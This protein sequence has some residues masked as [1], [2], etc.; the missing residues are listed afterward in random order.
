MLRVR[1]APRDQRG[2][3]MIEVMV[4]S[5]VLAIGVLGLVSL[6]DGAN[7]ALGANKEREGATNVARQVVE[8]VDSLAYTA[9]DPTTITSTLQSKPGLANTGGAGG[10]TVT[11]RGLSYQVA[12]SVTTNSTPINFKRVTATVTPAA[13]PSLKVTQSTLMFP[14]GISAGVPPVTNIT[15]NVASPVTSSSTTSVTFT[16]TTSG[17]PSGVVFFV[18]GNPVG[19]ATG[20]GST[21]TYPWSISG[22]SDGTYVISA[23]SFNSSG[24]YSD[25]YTVTF[26]LERSVPAAPTG[27]E[28]GYDPFEGSVDSQWFAS[29]ERNVVGYHVYRQ[30][31]SPTLG[32]ATQVN[33]GTVASPVY[34]VTSLNCTDASP[35]TGSGAVTA[36]QSSSNAVDGTKSF[37]LSKPAGVAAG[38]VLLAT[39]STN[40]TPTVTAPSG[41]TLAGSNQNGNNGMESAVYYKVATASEPATYTWTLSHKQDTTGGIVDYSGVDTTNPIDAIQSFAGNSG[42]A[43]GPPVTTTTANDAIVEAVGFTGAAMY[44]WTPVVP[45]GMTQRFHGNANGSESVVADKSQATAGSSG[46]FFTQADT[47]N[48]SSGWVAQT[49]ALKSRSISVNYWV[50]PCYYDT[51]SVLQEGTATTPINAYAAD[52]P[53]NAPSWTS[54]PLTTLSDGTT[55]L[56]WNLSSGDPDTGDSVEMYRIYRDG[57]RYDTVG[58]ST[59]SYIDSNP[60]GTTHSYYVTAVDTHME[61]STPTSTVTG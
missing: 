12:V 11:S 33:C 16:A 56:Q 46:W 22:L 19:T 47:T 14:G 9:A 38:D 52:S 3:T 57:Q 29:P 48:S 60:G 23:R 4:A 55:Q 36:G 6:V 24:T 45:S 20:S 44:S 54:T 15:S 35:L 26:T 53:P 42:T 41:W 31:T 58:G 17:T 34:L 59:S 10:W 7:K 5:L 37:S 21:W 25:A 2:F 49:I 39:I 1:T 61:E 32:S 27:F 40:A 13:A 50:V 8:D 30:Q 51:N 28:T 43:W 18:D